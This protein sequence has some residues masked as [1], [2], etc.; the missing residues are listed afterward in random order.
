[1]RRKSRWREMQEAADRSAPLRPV[2]IEARSLIV[3]I[4]GGADRRLMQRC[5]LGK[6]G[7]VDARHKQRE[8]SDERERR[9]GTS[10]SA[11]VATET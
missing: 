9:N 10:R 1:M 7:W 2:I 5:S 11:P 8:D 3:V 4:R 6:F